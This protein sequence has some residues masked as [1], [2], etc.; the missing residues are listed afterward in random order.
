MSRIHGRNGRLYLSATSGA[1]A[2]PVAFM[3]DW[4]ITYS[5]DYSDV[6]PL[7]AP[8]RTWLS[9]ESDVSG[10][11]AGWYDD[12]TLQE[13]SA[14]VDG[15]PRSFYLYPNTNTPSQYFQGVVNV[16]EFDVTSGVTAGAAV[17]GSWTTTG[18]VT[19][20]KNAGGTY[21]ASYSAT[22]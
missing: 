11:F 20:I 1:A 17:S 10:T 19:L 7:G 5:Q 3:S 4:A 13:Y 15:L 2:S 18:A 22:Y 14:A 6:T 21:S 12:A 8:A 16:T 9:T